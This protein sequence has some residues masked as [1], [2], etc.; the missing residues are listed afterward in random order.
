MV[1]VWHFCYV[2][3]DGWLRSGLLAMWSAFLK[4]FKLFIIREVM[5]QNKAKGKDDI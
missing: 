1:E 4:V 3:Q 2:E 5:G